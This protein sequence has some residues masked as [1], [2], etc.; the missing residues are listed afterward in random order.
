M[1]DSG[2]VRRV[3]RNRTTPFRTCQSSTAN[4]PA[5]SL[6]RVKAHGSMRESQATHLFI[7][8]PD[9][10]HPDRPTERRQGINVL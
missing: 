5:S 3:P 6:A 8:R 7:P 9:G 4:T 1:A 2:S 10:A